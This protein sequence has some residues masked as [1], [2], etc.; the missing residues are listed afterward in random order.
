MFSMFEK[1]EKLLFEAKPV[2]AIMIS[3][4]VDNKTYIMHEIREYESKADLTVKI[5]SRNAN[6]GVHTQTEK[7]SVSRD[8]VEM[9]V[10]FE[11]DGHGFLWDFRDH[12]LRYR[13]EVD[14][15]KRIEF[16]K[17]F[18]IVDDDVVWVER[19]YALDNLSTLC[20]SYAYD[21]GNGNFCWSKVDK[22]AHTVF[23]ELYRVV[24][25]YQHED[26]FEQINRAFQEVHNDGSVANNTYS[27][28][29][30]ENHSKEVEHAK[31]NYKLTMR[32]LDI[33]DFYYRELM[34]R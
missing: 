1:K 34:E 5:V 20:L 13:P 9:F 12:C 29:F 19:V 26:D 16:N 7:I 11:M 3:V 17:W 6:G 18:H 15:S 10:P 27:D 32:V 4:C 8:D 25:E 30:F 24:M 33:K 23:M 28:W 14:W 22:S 31:G 21:D 2:E